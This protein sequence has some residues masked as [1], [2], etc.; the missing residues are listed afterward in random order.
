MADLFTNIA[1]NWFLKFELMEI[2]R[3]NHLTL[4]KRLLN[5]KKKSEE[6]CRTKFVYPKFTTSQQDVS[7]ETQLFCVGFLEGDG[8]I[9]MCGSTVQVRIS[10]S[11]NGGIPEELR[12][13]GKIYGGNIRVDREAT[14][15]QRTQWSL[16]IYSEQCQPLLEAV[17]TFGILKAP[18][19]FAALQYINGDKQDTEEYK[20][21]LH[22][23]K[24]EYNSNK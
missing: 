18:Q 6:L 8:C 13:I 7:I 24:S 22:D 17:A 9:D 3:G 21:L 20:Y 14:E 2:E 10:Q 16:S 12:H 5:I 15:T 1:E 19:A 23:L 11:F 4:N